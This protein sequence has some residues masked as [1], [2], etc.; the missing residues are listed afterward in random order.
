M[1]AWLRRWLYPQQPLTEDQIDSFLEWVN[2]RPTPTESRID[3]QWFEAQRMSQHHSVSPRAAIDM[4]K[5]EA[6]DILKSTRPINLTLFDDLGPI[7]MAEVKAHLVTLHAPERSAVP[8]ISD[9]SIETL[10]AAGLPRETT[11]SLARCRVRTLQIG[12]AN[13]ADVH[14]TDTLIGTLEIGGRIRKIDIDG[15]FIGRIRINH[16]ENPFGDVTIRRLSL[17]RHMLGQNIQ[18]LRDTRKHL[19]DKGNTPA[20]SPF[21]AAELAL[22]RE[23]EPFWN[24]MVSHVYE[25]GSD[26]GNSIGR[27]LGWLGII[28]L[29]IAILSW[30]TG[31]VAVNDKDLAGWPHE[32]AE[33]GEWNRFVRG[34]VYAAQCVFNPLN[35]F[36]AKALTSATHSLYGLLCAG[37]GL[38][39]TLALALFLLA[40]RRRFKLE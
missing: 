18:W 30:A 7:N 27:P 15:G 28:I 24:R 22:D 4:A 40:I 10:H 37:L 23:H 36:T 13:S 33:P 26:F 25:I 32:I 16:N 3:R 6:S 21:H 39:G 11:L 31:L 20:A 2:E 9:K 5:A 29:V 35:L 12:N 17:A 38:L 1:W 34:V 14:L 8:E 19:T